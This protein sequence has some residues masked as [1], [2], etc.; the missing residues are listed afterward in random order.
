M[1]PLIVDGE[2]KGCGLLLP[3][4]ACQTALPVW[5]DKLPVWNEAE[6]LDVAKSGLMDGRK[7]FDPSWI[8]DQKSH[9]SCNG[10]AGAAALSRS[11]V[12]RG[13]PRVDLSGAYLYSLINGGQDRGS[14]LDDGMNAIQTKG[15]ATAA[16]VGWDQIYPHQYDR[17]K[18]DAEASQYKAFE[19]YAVKTLPGLWTALAADWDCVVAVHAGNSFMRVGTDGVAGVDGGPGNHAVAVDGLFYST[20]L[21][22]LVACG[23]NS[24]GTQYG[25]QGRMG[26]T[27][28]HFAQ[29][30]QYHA[31][32]AI[33]ST[34]D[35]STA[36]N[37]PEAK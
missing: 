1:N 22:R 25:E 6:I 15:I 29:P 2:E 24:W 19:A 30:M 17:S 14:M 35:G 3:P 4:V 5:E 28:D 20:K 7:L 21:G 16:T 33:R 8:K 11:R 34:T 12:R 31:Y 27:E 18:A 37:P 9:G 10:F 32:Y 36:D 26:L 13:L 23:V